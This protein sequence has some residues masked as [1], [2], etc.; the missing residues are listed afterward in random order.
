MILTRVFPFARPTDVADADATG[1][2]DLADADARDRISALYRPPRP[3]WTRLNL[4][5]T[6]SGSA[7]GPDGT[8]ESITSTTDRA[9]LRA[10]RGL[11]DVVLVGAASVRVEPYFAP[12]HAALAIVS[13]SGDFSAR[14]V[15]RPG[16]HG[17]L[18]VL[19]PASA[20][21]RARRTIGDP[22]ARIL[23]VPDVGGSLSATAIVAALRGAGFS[24]IVAEGGPTIAA[25]LL[26]GGV[27]DEVCLTTSPLLNG[28]RLPLFG[29]AEFGP[30]PLA[31]TQLLVDDTGTS[32]ARWRVPRD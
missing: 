12:R 2:I 32:Y 26:T 3:N 17:P 19:C 6:V 28:A 8:S 13:R 25:H 10:I 20:V 14:P 1:A 30:V 22:D 31:L 29:V 5:G 15:T 16:E 9:I 4:V 23:V 27:V 21:A 18:V 11:A 24:S 7:I